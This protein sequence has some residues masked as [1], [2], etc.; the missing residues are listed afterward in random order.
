MPFVAIGPHIK[1]GYTGT[2]TYSHSSFL[3][4]VEEIFGLPVL[5]TV[6]GANDLANL[7]Q[8]ATFP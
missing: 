7:F 4:S 2:V 8:P 3:K 5:P 6:A 1:S